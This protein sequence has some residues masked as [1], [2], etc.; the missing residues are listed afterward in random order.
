V[1]DDVPRYDPNEP[2]EWFRPETLDSPRD[3]VLEILSLERD[4]QKATDQVLAWHTDQI[5]SRDISLAGEQLCR[6]LLHLLEP[7]DIRVRIIA[8][9]FAFSLNRIHGYRSIRDAARTTGLCAALISAKVVEIRERYSLPSNEHS[10]SET[11]R[12]HYSE[13]QKQKHWRTPKCS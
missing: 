4:P 3:Q 2:R 7:G 10:K 9:S 1:I 11:A 6:I 12:E 13:A 5:A 8:Y